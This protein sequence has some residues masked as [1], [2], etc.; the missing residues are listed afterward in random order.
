MFCAKWFS[1]EYELSF[2]H[3]FLEKPQYVK[4]VDQNKTVEKLRFTNFLLRF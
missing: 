2:K 4:S 3:F 1:V